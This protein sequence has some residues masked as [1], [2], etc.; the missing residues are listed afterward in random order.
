LSLILRQGGEDLVEEWELEGGRERRGSSSPATGGG[1]FAMR[2]LREG[3][4]PSLKEYVPEAWACFNIAHIL[5]RDAFNY[6][7][8]ILDASL[9]ILDPEIHK[10][11]KQT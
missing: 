10:K 3:K 7:L 1:S 11:N 9:F 4:P 6:L 2:I 8:V 5:M